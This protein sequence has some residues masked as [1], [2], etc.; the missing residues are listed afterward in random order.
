MKWNYY[1]GS[2]LGNKMYT[3]REYIQFPTNNGVSESNRHIKNLGTKYDEAYAKA[4]DYAKEKNMPLHASSIDKYESLN[5]I[6]RKTPEYYA[7]I[8]EDLQVKIDDFLQANPVLAQ[9]FETYNGDADNEVQEIGIAFYDI[10][11]KL[12]QYGNLS[13]DQV[14]FCLQMVDSYI[15]RKENQK[16]WKEEKDNAEPVPVTD[17]RIQFTGEVIKTTYKE[18]YLPNGMEVGSQKCTLKDDR[19]FVV[20]GGNIGEKG[21]KVSFMAT[22][23]VSDNDPKFGFYKRPTKIQIL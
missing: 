13:V 7:K 18:H 19:G 12:Y 4:V 20:W 10:K 17:A 5:P 23:V 2:G 1:I 6:I 16:Q 15:T 14:S 8:Q 11:N 22:V 21:D 9:H 3:L